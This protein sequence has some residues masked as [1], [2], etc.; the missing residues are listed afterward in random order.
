MS[1]KKDEAKKSDKKIERV[2][3]MGSLERA[4]DEI[5]RL[6]A[7]STDEVEIDFSTC[8]F[9]AVEGLEWLEELLLRADSVKRT[10][11]FVN[12]PP[13]IYK[14]FK[15]SHIESLMKAAGGVSSTKLGPA[16]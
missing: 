15:I 11:R 16:C 4:V 8:T 13:T 14:V 5:D 2:R 7:G 3:I 9:I 6:L 10:V 1:T 12:V